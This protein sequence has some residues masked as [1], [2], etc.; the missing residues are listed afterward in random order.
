MRVVAFRREPFM[1]N[2]DPL[3]KGQEVFLKQPLQ[4]YATVIGPADFASD[5]SP[6]YCLKLQPQTQYYRAEDLE[7]SENPRLKAAA[8]WDLLERA[9][10]I[11]QRVAR[12]AY[13][14]FESRGSSHGHDHEDW[15]SAQAEIVRNVPVD[16]RERESD[17]TIYAEVPGFSEESLEIQVEP[18]ALCIASCPQD[19]S[20]QDEGKFIYS[21]RHANPIFRVIDLPSP[22]DPQTAA[23]ALSDGVLEIRI[24]KVV[25]GREMAAQANA[26]AG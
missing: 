15:I 10:E 18:L 17:L 2:H 5:G 11:N 24:S 3:K 16:I 25:A 21:E 26:A 14:L 12:R 20:R 9:Q 19:A 4:I 7:L 1:P 8:R 22:V 23:L 6:V 13:E